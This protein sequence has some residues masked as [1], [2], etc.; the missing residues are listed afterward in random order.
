MQT[1]CQGRPLR[2]IGTIEAPIASRLLPPQS[3]I[4][5]DEPSHR[6]WLWSERAGRWMQPSSTSQ[7]L[8]AAGEKGF[9]SFFWRR[10]LIEKHGMTPREADLY[11]DLH[12]DNRAGIGT[13]LHGLIRAELLGE[14]FHP[15]QA[16]SLTL[17]S[18]WRREFLP[19]VSAVVLC[20]APLASRNHFYTGTPDL[21]ARVDGLWLTTD[22]KTKVEEEKAKPEKAWRLQL[23]GYD[24]LVEENHAIR[25]DGALNLMIWQKGCKDVFYNRADVNAAREQFIG[26]LAW[27]H[28][29]RASH[30]CQDHL[31]AL[32]HLLSQRPEA[33]TLQDAPATVPEQAASLLLEGGAEAV[34]SLFP[35]MVH[36]GEARAEAHSAA[37]RLLYPCRSFRTATA[38]I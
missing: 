26:C 34:R 8:Q 31:G 16:E 22:W 38:T 33:F 27:S 5:F 36:D 20:E 9:D 23:G 6:Y 2:P 29:Q 18:V 19:R 14:S 11:M 35:V 17:L 3:G 24:A 1:D 32:L 25:A 37:Q 28:V 13:E 4:H 15:K 10:S 12:R 7:V 21:F 30:G